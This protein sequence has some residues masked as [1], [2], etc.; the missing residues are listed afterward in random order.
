MYGSCPARR[1]R[2]R[3][4]ESRRV[5]GQTMMRN[6]KRRRSI[7]QV[8]ALEALLPLSSAAGAGVG[9]VASRDVTAVHE[10]LNAQAQLVLQGTVKGNFTQRSGN[11]DTGAQYAFST[12]G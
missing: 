1:A 2:R 12:S 10:R 11:P 8:E 3:S 5:E 7:P 9:A 6:T 4:D